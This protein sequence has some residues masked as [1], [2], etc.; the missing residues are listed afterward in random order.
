MF[1]FNSPYCAAQITLYDHLLPIAPMI[2]TSRKL[3]FFGAFHGRAQNNKAAP[4]TTEGG[5]EAPPSNLRI[6]EI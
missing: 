5:A 2:D 1:V 3:A 4:R 6:S